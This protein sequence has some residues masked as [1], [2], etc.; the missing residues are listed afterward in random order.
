MSQAVLSCLQMR[1]SSTARESG[2]GFFWKGDSFMPPGMEMGQGHKPSRDVV[3]MGWGGDELMTFPPTRHG[4]SFPV[5]GAPGPPAAPGA[6]GTTW[7]PCRLVCIF[8]Q[9]SYLPQ[10][11]PL[12]PTSE[13]PHPTNL[14]PSS[15]STT[16]LCALCTPSPLSSTLTACAPWDTPHHS[17]GPFPRPVLLLWPTTPRLC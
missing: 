15:T 17:Q 14:H 3:A 8:P 2:E 7:L 6:S 1:S 16:L 13:P 10:P 9:A 5:P 12:P 4:L 11:H